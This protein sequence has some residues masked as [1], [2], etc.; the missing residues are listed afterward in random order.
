MVRQELTNWR[1]QLELRQPSCRIVDT[2]WHRQY[3]PIPRKGKATP[4]TD[5]QA[6]IC[7]NENPGMEVCGNH[8]LR[9]ELGI[10]GETGS[11]CQCPDEDEQG[12]KSDHGVNP[13]KET[14]RLTVS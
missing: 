4:P 10:V 6:E 3:V 9:S 12:I 5:S 2:E 13:N 1:G 8:E 14:H 7:G 11:S